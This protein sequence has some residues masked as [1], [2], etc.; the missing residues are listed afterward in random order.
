MKQT[1]QWLQEQWYKKITSVT[2]SN[3]QPTKTEGAEGSNEWAKSQIERHV[4]TQ[5]SAKGTP[6]SNP[7]N[8]IG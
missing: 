6:Q 3:Q 4:I 8:Y 7:A 5:S 2:I 1:G